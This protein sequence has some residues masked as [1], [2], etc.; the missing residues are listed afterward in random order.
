MICVVLASVPFRLTRLCVVLMLCRV[1]QRSVII[2]YQLSE[3]NFTRDSRG[4]LQLSSGSSSSQQSSQNS[5]QPNSQT[6]REEESEGG[7]SSAAA[8]ASAPSP[9]L[10]RWA[11][12]P[13]VRL[14]GGK[15]KNSNGGSKSKRARSATGSQLDDSSQQSISASQEDD[16]PAS[17]RS[18]GECSQEEE[19]ERDDG[20]QADQ[21]REGPGGV[22]VKSR[23]LIYPSRNAHRQ[24]G[25]ESRDQR[26]PA[27]RSFCSD[28]LRLI[29]LRSASLVTHMAAT[30]LQIQNRL[31]ANIRSEWTG[32]RVSR[33]ES[34]HLSSPSV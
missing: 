25:K 7:A 18:F 5:S 10:S 4:V 3:K 17:Q 21:L 28:E 8:S 6:K 29:C 11:A 12:T 26:E 19:G 32:S 27:S 24:L 22:R 13:A 31:Y 30:Y 15:K 1:V 16:D 2:Q 20:E 14:S 23:Q 9:P 34:V 33:D